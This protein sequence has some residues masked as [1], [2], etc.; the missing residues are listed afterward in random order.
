MRAFTKY[1]EELINEVGTKLA[2]LIEYLKEHDKHSIIFSQWDDLLRKVGKIL[3]QNGVKNVFCRGNVFQRDKAVREFNTD[4]KI[5]V[6][7]LSSES[8]ASGT[9][10]TKAT[11]II[12]LDPVYGDY[13]YRKDTENQAIGRAHR[14][15]QKEQLEVVRFVVKETVEEEI[16]KMNLEEDKK[17]TNQFVKEIKEEVVAS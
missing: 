2:N 17:H 14:L 1:L 9:N 12:L 11:Q 8:A 5:K 4:D 16:Y 13:K 10:L 6:I 15:G 7:M 3:A